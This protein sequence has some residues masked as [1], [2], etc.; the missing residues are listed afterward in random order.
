MT[1]AQKHAEAQTKKNDSPGTP[2]G[3][4]DATHIKVL[5]GIEAVRTRPA[6][7]IGDTG[8]RGLHHLIN[9]VVDNS[10]DEALGGYCNSIT[11]RLNHEGS[12][13]V[14]DNG[15]GIPVDMHK[16]QKKPALEVVMTMLHAGGKFDQ[17]SYKVSGGLHGVGVS[18]VNALSEWLEVEVWRDGYEYFQKYERGHPAT[19]VEKRGK[20]TKQGTSVTFKPDSKIFP[21]TKFSFD[22][23]TSRLRELA[24][25]NKGI[26]ITLSEEKTS[27][28]ETF[29][30]EGG[31]KSFIEHLNQNKKRIHSDIVYFEKE[32]RNSGDTIYVEI[33][34]QYNDGYS[35]ILFCYAN[36]I[37]TIEGGTHLS[38][39]RTALTRTLNN[40]A[41]S[42]DLLKE[43][44]KPPVG[45]D[46]R[47]GL[48]AIINIRLP[49]PQFEGQTKTKL[50]NREIEGIVQAIVNDGLATY[51][52]EHPATARLIINKVILAS[53][54]REAARKARDLT[55]RKD[56]LY[57]GGLPGKLAD[58][59]S[60][61]LEHTELYIVE[62]DSAGGSAK[63]GRNREFQA[64]LPLKGKILNVEKARIEKMLSHE[65]IRTLITA[66]G[67]GI[68][69]EEFD[70]SK[71]RY[72][73]IIIMTDADV[74]GSHIRTLLLT[75]FFRHMQKIIEQ[76]RLYIAQPPLFKVKYGK[77]EEYILSDKEMHQKLLDMAL[78]NTQLQ[79]NI[80]KRDKY[81]LEKTH[82]KHLVEKVA[83]LEE[84]IYG[85][86]VRG[87]PPLK[88]FQARDEKTNHFPLYYTNLIGTKIEHEEQFFQTDNQLNKYIREKEKELKKEIIL[89]PQYEDFI[90]P[91]SNNGGKKD[92]VITQISE[93]ASVLKYIEF[94]QN[95][96]IESLVK[97]IEKLLPNAFDITTYL[98]KEDDIS[99]EG[100]KIKKQEA[101]AKKD[102]KFVGIYEL[103]INPDDKEDKDRIF[104]KS[105]RDL[106]KGIRKVGQRDLEIQRYKGL[107]EMNPEQLWETTMDPVRRSLL[108]VKI[109]D[110]VKADRMFTILMGEEVE[111]RRDFIEKH[112]LEVKNLDI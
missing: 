107:G 87:V 73:K 14:I 11:V 54:A 93:G 41:K 112:S 1:S 49:N 78:D 53:R 4:Y 19:K 18:V 76:E 106:L 109:E 104:L 81:C 60:R 98:I 22:A 16:E 111:P 46:Y 25:L 74:D 67:T 13:T 57:S 26:A 66:L 75:F 55:R 21:D 84:Y 27:R 15:R 63:Q 108:K 100:C 64:I 56:A 77:K 44:D 31:I 38:G 72:G 101:A 91:A 95:K 32:D 99:T 24:F 90:E 45:D 69:T 17:K 34:M 37:N 30:Y 83:L 12:V 82:L 88:Y 40:Y 20:S 51:L 97:E 10:I 85:I 92:R 94:F 2:S 23:V 71:L 105:L 52:E 79:I 47:E 58:C 7:Y 50:G 28:T 43:A 3:H 9:E 89:M 29:K 110:A 5:G 61:D 8:P 62:G 65:E 35:E 6:M 39:Y 33:A 70:M 103:I 48:T 80:S 42:H 96:D 86:K 59:S 68:G 102:E 36:N